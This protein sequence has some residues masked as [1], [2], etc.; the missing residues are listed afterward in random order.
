MATRGWRPEPVDAV[1]ADFTRAQVPSSLQVERPCLAGTVQGVS[2]PVGQ[3]STNGAAIRRAYPRAGRIDTG[4]Q[5]AEL[6]VGFGGD[7]AASRDGG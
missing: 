7:A 2:N 6:A 3:A 4:P 5:G 1:A